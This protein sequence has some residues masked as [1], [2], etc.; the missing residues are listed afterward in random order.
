MLINALGV[1]EAL[2]YE[3]GWRPCCCQHFIPHLDQDMG[4]MVVESRLPMA[5]DVQTRRSLT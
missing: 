4:M 5:I 3:E 2:S 1:Q